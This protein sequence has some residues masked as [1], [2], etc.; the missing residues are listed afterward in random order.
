MLARFLI[1]TTIIAIAG[2]SANLDNAKAFD[3]GTCNSIF[4][5]VQDVD[6]VRASAGSVDFGDGWHL[7][8]SPTGDAV[9]CW[10]NW[11]GEVAIKGRLYADTPTLITAAFDITYT[12]GSGRTETTEMLGFDGQN[13]ESVGITRWK[14]CCVNKVRIRLYNCGSPNSTSIDCYVVTSISRNRGD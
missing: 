8:G 11:A 6:R 5:E 1:L 13:G 9:I 2:L 10:S 12:F 14:G 3:A 7:N 4:Y